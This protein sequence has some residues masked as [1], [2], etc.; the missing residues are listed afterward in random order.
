M[1]Y[2]RYQKNGEAHYGWLDGTRVG[3]VIGE[4][5]GDSK[6]GGI[7]AD[8]REVTILPPATPSKIIAVGQNYVARALEQGLEPPDIPPLCL[9]P[10]SAVIGHYDEIVIPPQSAQVEHEAELA[11][12]IGRRARWVSVEDALKFVWGY[13]CAND[14]TA[15]DLERR[16][17]QLT[18]GKGFDTFCPLGPWVSTDVDAADVVV[19]CK[20]NG[21]VRQMSSTRELRFSVPQLVAFISSVMTLE[22]GDVI[23][24]GTPAGVGSLLPGDQVEVEIEGIGTLVNTVT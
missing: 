23:L 2:L 13:T 8:L 7:V 19:M 15:R 21:Q 17:S 4:V 9:K 12:I 6:R 16:D 24:T 10:P 5:F 11:V 22:P 20:V 1:I 14:V 3:A 18:R